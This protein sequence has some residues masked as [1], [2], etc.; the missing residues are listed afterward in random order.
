MTAREVRPVPRALSKAGLST[1]ALHDPMIGEEPAFDFT[2][3]VGKG[4]A[5]EPAKGFKSALDAQAEAR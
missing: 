3:T 1:V 4:P 2:H 5:Q